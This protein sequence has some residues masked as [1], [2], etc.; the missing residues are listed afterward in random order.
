PKGDGWLAVVWLLSVLFHL[1]RWAFRSA[2]GSGLLTSAAVHHGVCLAVCV[3][4]PSA[5]LVR[6]VGFSFIC[7]GS[8]VPGLPL[9]PGRRRSA[10]RPGPLDIICRRGDCR[11]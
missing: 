4:G 8:G 7:F 11:A 5:G 2:L 1:S 6:A 3:T 10:T 9:H